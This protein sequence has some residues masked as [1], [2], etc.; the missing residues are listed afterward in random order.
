MADADVT[1]GGGADPEAPAKIDEARDWVGAKLDEM[2]G[3]TVGRV[4]SLLVDA[5]DGEPTWAVARLGRFGRRTAVPAEFVAAGVGHVWVPF[6]RETIKAGS[7][8][9]PSGGLSVEDERAL[10]ELYEIPAGAGRAAA[11]A[12]RDDADPGSVPA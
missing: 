12:E 1:P 2:E 5:E 11:I 7:E 9:D 6:D 4:E 8:V 10:C 3:T